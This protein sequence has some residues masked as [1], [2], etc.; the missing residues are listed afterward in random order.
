[1]AE[2]ASSFWDVQSQSGLSV[3]WPDNQSETSSLSQ[4]FSQLGGAGGSS[5]PLIDLD[6]VRN[7]HAFTKKK[8]INNISLIGWFFN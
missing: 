2:N 4:A 7:Y 6:D 1:M 5:A 8:T 3:D